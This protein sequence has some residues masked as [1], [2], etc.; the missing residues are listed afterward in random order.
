[1]TRILQTL[2]RRE[3][4]LASTVAQR[5]LL[6]GLS[7]PRS[8]DDALSEADL[9]PLH[10]TGLDIL[11][12][13][14][15]KRCNQTCR[16]CHVDAGPDRAEVMP[17]EVMEA[18]LRFLERA[19]IGTLDI[20]GGAPE[21]HPDFREL[22]RRATALGVHVM[23]RCNLTAILL[24][25]YADIPEL[26]AGHGVE[27]VASLPYFQA[28]ETDAQRGEG[29]FDESVL[30]L[31]RLN[32]LG[33]GRGNGLVL[34]LVT[35]PVGMFLPGNQRE[36]EAMWKRELRR[37]HEIEFDRLYTITNMPISRFLE[38]LEARGR[39]AEYVSRLVNAFNPAA[40][41]GVMCRGMLSVGWDG[42]LYDC[43]FNQMLDLP[44]ADDVPR[45][46]FDAE[47]ALLH[48]RRIATG[49]HCFGCTAGGG[50][51][52]GGAVA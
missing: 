5:A 42:T 18:V 52:C 29:V 40:A 10:A 39:T 46:I 50:S 3:A 20:T 8:F 51:S 2:H 35:N 32:A 37:R 28:R 21:L 25:N 11:Q 7:L 41:A 14:V 30:G 43:D 24:P 26:L 27:I 4:P 45:T 6:D 12:V 31:R 49:P 17:R 38:F 19:R 48:G 47:R 34:N 16:H 36:L 13:N 15:G 23:H 33:Y 1:M 9:L 44:L 22:V